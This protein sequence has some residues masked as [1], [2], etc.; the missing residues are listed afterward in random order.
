MGE[1]SAPIEHSVAW[2]E[3]YLH[4]KFQLDPSNRLATIDQCHRQTDRTDRKGQLSD[5]IER[6]VLQ[7]V[8]QE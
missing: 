4:A 5:S 2:A 6:A 7:T 1:L 8:T 3:A